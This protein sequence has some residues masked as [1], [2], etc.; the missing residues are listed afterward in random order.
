MTTYTRIEPTEST[1]GASMTE[2]TYEVTP[3]FFSDKETLVNET[4]IQTSK[5]EPG[6]QVRQNSTSLA[7]SP[8]RPA[9]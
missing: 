6:C 2:R 8:A 3:G 7:P 1:D 4:T 9:A 5:E